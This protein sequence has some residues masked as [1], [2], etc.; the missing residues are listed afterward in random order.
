MET[1]KKKMETLNF[2][3]SEMKKKGARK[4]KGSVWFGFIWLKIGPGS[5][6]LGTL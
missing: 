5:G 3:G 1:L 2:A 4:E 6:F